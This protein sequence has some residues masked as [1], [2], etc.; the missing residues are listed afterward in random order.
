MKIKINGYIKDINNNIITRFT[1]KAI[2]TKTKISYILNNEKYTLKIITF[3][4][5]VLIR[6]NNEI[7]NIIYFEL[8]KTISSEYIIK[9]NNITLDIDIKTLDL[10]INHNIINIMYL[11]I[12]SQSKYE[13]KIEM[14]D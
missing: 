8:N 13:Y 1:E 12:D 2:K 7:K 4:K 6:E 9:Q 14:S 11:V 10:V 3:K 5:L